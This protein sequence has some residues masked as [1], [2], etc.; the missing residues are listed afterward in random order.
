MVDGSSKTVSERLRLMGELSDAML[1]NLKPIAGIPPERFRADEAVELRVGTPI[2]IES[3]AARSGFGVFFEDD[4]E[5]G[6]F[7]GLDRKSDSAILDALHIYTVANVTDAN[8][9]SRVQIFWSRDWLKCGLSINDYI[10]AVFD[11]ESKR[12]YCRT[13]FPPIDDWSKDAHVWSDD[14]IK[15]FA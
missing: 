3:Q 13:G 15:L 10:H 9:P 8:L 4:R 14:A 2:V 11:F 12:G 6:Y 7:Y 5:T 1:T